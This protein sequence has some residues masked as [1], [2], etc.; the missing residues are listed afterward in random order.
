MT[1]ADEVGVESIRRDTPRRRV[2]MRPSA[3]VREVRNR[4]SNSSVQ[5]LSSNCPS[6]AESFALPATVWVTATTGTVRRGPRSRGG[7]PRRKVGGRALGD[8]EPGRAQQG[9]LLGHRA[10]DG[11]AE[12]L[13]GLV[14]RAR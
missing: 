6:V 4:N 1:V 13:R 9:R 2:S 12:L 5:A 3:P 7:Q 8:G 10:A 14:D 11:L